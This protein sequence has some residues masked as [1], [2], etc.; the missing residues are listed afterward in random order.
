MSENEPKQSK[1]FKH[2]TLATVATATIATGFMVYQG[3]AKEVVEEPTEEVIEVS[4]EQDNIGEDISAGADAEDI[5]EADSHN[6]EENS[7]NEDLEET[8]PI[9]EDGGDTED[10]TNHSVDFRMSNR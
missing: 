2:I 9:E 4:E 6:D 7:L 1:T 8:K 3:S 10:D 5:A